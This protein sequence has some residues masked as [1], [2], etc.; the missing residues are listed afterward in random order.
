MRTITLPLTCRQL[1]WIFLIVLPLISIIGYIDD[2]YILGNILLM[3]V[4]SFS[5]IGWGVQI[6]WWILDE[7]AIKCKC[8]K[9]E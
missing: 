5:A 6:L 4:I 2:S 9:D 3:F 7:V 1:K 8:D